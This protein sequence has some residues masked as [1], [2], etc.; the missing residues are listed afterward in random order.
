MDEN[1]END[2]FN[3]YD[4]VTKHKQ[5]FILLITFSQCLL[6]IKNTWKTLNI[7]LTSGK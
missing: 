3:R 4:L 6:P 5:V 2:H 7:F 1:S